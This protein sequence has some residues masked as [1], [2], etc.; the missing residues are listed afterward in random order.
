MATTT[1]LVRANLVHLDD[2]IEILGMMTTV[3]A[4]ATYPGDVVGVH[5]T[6]SDEI[7]SVALET[8]YGKNEFVKVHITTND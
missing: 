3:V 2:Q 6:Y 4:I 5:S 1:H 7:G 8:K